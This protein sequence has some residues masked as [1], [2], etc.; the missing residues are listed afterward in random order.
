MPEIRRVFPGGNTCEGFFSY[1]RYILDE[2][3]TFIL[4]GGPGSG[5]STLMKNMANEMIK[6]GLSIEYHHCS[7]DKTS[8][9]GIL[10]KELNTAILDGTAPHVIEP[11]L[12]GLSDDIVDLGK[13]ID[14]GKLLD[15]KERILKAK[16]NNKRSYRKTYSY[17]RAGKEILKEIVY[18]NK[19]K[20]DFK[21]FDE[22]YLD[23]R[24]EIY[25]SETIDTMG[26]ERHLFNRSFTPSGLA[27]YTDTILKGRRIYYI[28]A[29]YGTGKSTLL[30]RISKEGLLR[31]YDVDIFHEPLIPQK[32]NTIIVPELNLALSATDYARKNYYKEI[33]LN[34][35]LKEDIKNKNDHNIFNKLIEIGIRNLSE[36][37]LNHDILEESYRPAIDFNGIEREKEKL[38]KEI[39]SLA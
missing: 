12:P 24:D 11:I 36:A 39:L 6:Y 32:I 21:G 5:K 31:G 10:I 17:F 28:K 38:A 33:D 29:E 9:D 13:Y 1:H 27:D 34:N 25:N 20:V 15:N 35:F 14:R 22:L 26:K 19:E 37:K 18:E 7:S 8:I 4:K 16:L 30:H 23:L 3:R 2:G